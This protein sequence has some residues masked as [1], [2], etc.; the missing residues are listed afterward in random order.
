MGGPLIAHKCGTL[1]R[2]VLHSQLY[3]QLKDFGDVLL[4]L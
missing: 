2:K 3:Q 1:H 4:Y